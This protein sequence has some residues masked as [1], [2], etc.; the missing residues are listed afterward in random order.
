[1]P[2]PLSP[3]RT[4]ATATARL[5]Y[6]TVGDPDSPPV[7]LI[8]G[9]GAQSLGWHPDFCRTLADT[10]Y[11]VIRPDNRDVG[12][13]QKF[14]AGNYTLGD[15]A[16]DI[17]G[18][19]RALDIDTAHIVGQSMGG[20]IAQE[21]A[22]REPALVRSTTLIYTCAHPDRIDTGAIAERG[23]NL[24][25]V[26][27]DRDQAIAAYLENESYC[28]GTAYPA[29]IDW[30]TDLGGQLYDRDPTSDAV[31]RQFDAVLSSRDRR[32]LLPSIDTPTAILC[33]DSDRLID[34]QA[35]TELHHLIPR[36]TLT[37]FAGMGHSLPRPLWKD[38]VD[39]IDTN[40]RISE[41]AP[42]ATP[43]NAR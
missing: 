5:S 7:I 13:S 15:M 1:M 9:L 19:I 20:M 36:S 11:H 31:P 28:A 4:V 27:A 38:I 8:Q 33:G 16:A 18:L 30:L 3:P 23:E 22:L 43:T 10:G 21:L 37:I 42:A 24:T 25:T 41:S 14:P 40:C 29:D 17:A 35:S 32:P 26:P 34:P 2:I 39:I 12:L 6:D